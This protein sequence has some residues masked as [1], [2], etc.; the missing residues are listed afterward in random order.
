MR[1]H[2][3]SGRGWWCG[4]W[5]N[6]SWGLRLMK[7]ILSPQ[8][9]AAEITS[10][11]DGVFFSL[12]IYNLGFLISWH[13]PLCYPPSHERFSAASALRIPAKEIAI[14]PRL[15]ETGT[16]TAGIASI[17]SKRPYFLTN[18]RPRRQ[19]ILVYS[20]VGGFHRTLYLVGMR[21]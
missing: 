18:L 5:R 11:V 6:V 7:S 19:S 17:A 3:I 15:P 9:F 2:N 13:F 20:V 16:R 10:V 14:A 21:W 12:F 4:V 1:Y 8:L